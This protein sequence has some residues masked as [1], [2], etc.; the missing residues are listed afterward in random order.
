MAHENRLR[1][2][3]CAPLI[4]VAGY[5]LS[6]DAI[7]YQRC[8]PTASRPWHG[9]LNGLAVGIGWGS[10][11]GVPLPRVHTTCDYATT[12]GE[13]RGRRAA[14]LAQRGGHHPHTVGRAERGVEINVTLLWRDE[15]PFSPSLSPQGV[16][17]YKYL[18]MG[19]SSLS[20]AYFV[21]PVRR[22]F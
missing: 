1:L 14:T 19:G 17:Y 11:R 8:R 5:S 6:L 10:Y 20:P 9:N 13:H 18:Y 16:R 12:K 3:F 15:T 7:R 2:S 21:G 4:R 22:V